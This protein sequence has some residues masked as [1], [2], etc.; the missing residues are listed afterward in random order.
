MDNKPRII[1][2]RR[3]QQAKSAQERNHRQNYMVY[4]LHMKFIKFIRIFLLV[5]IIIGI[6]LLATQKMWVPKL[7]EI[8]FLV[9]AL[10]NLVVS[11]VKQQA[12]EVFLPPLV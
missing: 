8:I 9:E 3:N 12:F 1:S 7:V 10:V 11:A 2:E 4:F 5:L 6:G